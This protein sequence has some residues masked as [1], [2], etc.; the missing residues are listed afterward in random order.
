V[1]DAWNRIR[2]L[3]ESDGLDGGEV[4]PGFRHTLDSLFG[5][6]AEENGKSS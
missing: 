1:Y 2:V 3:T 6:V 4:L 5:P